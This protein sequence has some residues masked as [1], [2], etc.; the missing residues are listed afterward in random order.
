MCAC[1]LHYMGMC[2]QLMHWQF[3]ACTTFV[4]QNVT[5][6]FALHWL[7]NLSLSSCTTF[8]QNVTSIYIND[9]MCIFDMHLLF[10]QYHLALCNLFASIWCTC[11][12]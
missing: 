2:S 3:E 6:V 12:E 5:F 9:I 4:L 7:Y 1:Q 10:I 8:V 11:R